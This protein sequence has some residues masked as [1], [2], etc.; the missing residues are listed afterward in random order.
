MSISDFFKKKR[1]ENNQRN[2]N[3]YLDFND[4]QIGERRHWTVDALIE[5][6]K[7]SLQVG[8]AFVRWLPEGR[9]S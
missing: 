1:K 4:V 9:P 8:K 7:Y 5:D 6:V 2:E 3:N